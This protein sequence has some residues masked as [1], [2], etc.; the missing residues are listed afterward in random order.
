[1]G[2]NSELTTPQILRLL[3]AGASGA[4]MIALGDGPL[5]TKDLT[6]RVRGYT[7]RTIYRY[8]SKLVE[9]GILERHEEAGVPSKVTHNLS[10]PRGRELYELVLAY[11]DAS[12]TRLPDGRIDAHAWGSLAI[13]ADLWE[14]GLIEELNLG[15]KSPTELAQLE[16]G[17]SY[18]QVNRRAGLFAIGGF[19]REDV[20]LGNRR[21]YSLT[22]RA[23]R[24][25]ALIAGVGRWRRH[26][27]VR[28]GSS[29]LTARET[30]E[31]LRT[32]LPLV[33]LPE[34]GG[35][36]LGIEI[37]AVN[38]KEGA[39][40]VWTVVEPKGNLLSC[41]GP[42]SE[43]DGNARGQV[44]TFVDAILDGSRDGMQMEGDERLIKACFERLHSILWQVW[45]L[46]STTPAEGVTGGDDSPEL[47]YS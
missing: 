24:G 18:H 1:L 3:G 7:P 40:A 20:G 5:R 22:D 38:R 6:E 36:R 37:G 11:A 16:H 25:M 14:S 2:E 9:A 27:V 33:A 43:V 39:D 46:G 4:I 31:V 29:G 10:E 28:K 13:L 32:A 23:R 26:H 30:G 35:K 8:S 34:H 42:L 12:F 41:D 15:P 45:P 17:L 47:S 19:L 21:M 44:V